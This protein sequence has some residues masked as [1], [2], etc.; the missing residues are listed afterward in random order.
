MRVYECPF[1][2]FTALA[3]RYWT[4]EC[5]GMRE[6]LAGLGVTPAELR[7]FSTVPQPLNGETGSA[8]RPA[9]TLVSPSPKGDQP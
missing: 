7:E 5:D 2:P 8:A 3:V 1:C 4:H 9:L 6:A